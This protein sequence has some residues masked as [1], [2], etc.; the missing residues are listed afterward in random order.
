LDTNDTKQPIS[1]FMKIVKG[2]LIH[3]EQIDENTGSDPY[4][5]AKYFNECIELLSL[6]IPEG[7]G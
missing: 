4:G 2:Q 7:N 5:Q 6:D 1:V 3:D